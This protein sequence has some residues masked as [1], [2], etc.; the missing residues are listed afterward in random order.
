MTTDRAVEDGIPPLHIALIAMLGLVF[1]F[2]VFRTFAALRPS[3]APVRRAAAPPTATPAAVPSPEASPEF[4]PIVEILTPVETP[5][6]AGAII[7]AGKVEPDLADEVEGE[8]LVKARAGPRKPRVAGASPRPRPT[9]LT[10]VIVPPDVAPSPSAQ[11]PAPPPVPETVTLRGKIT[12]LGARGPIPIRNHP[13][14]LVDF[15]NAQTEHAATDY[16]G[17][18]SFSYLKPGNLYYVVATL[19]MDSVIGHHYEYRPPAAP[20]GYGDT[21]QVPTLERVQFSWH[22]A[23]IAPPPGSYMLELNPYNA[24]P[25]FCADVSPTNDP[26][27]RTPYRS[28]RRSSLEPDAAPRVPTIPLN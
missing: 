15:A 1:L 27:T 20:A 9:P 6:D 26:I 28:W 13:V 16:E 5:A 7:I 11:P 10:V 23:I 19:E 21:Q 12:R 2:C 18:Y 4:T 22:Q 8:V 14:F 25:E 24:D 17:R 3:P